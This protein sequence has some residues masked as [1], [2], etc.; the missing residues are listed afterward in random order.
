MKVKDEKS[1]IHLDDDAEDFDT[2]TDID[3]GSSGNEDQDTKNGSN[4]SPGAAGANRFVL[5]IVIGFVAILVVVALVATSSYKSPDD[6]A[7]GIS[8]SDALKTSVVDKTDLQ[9]REP[10]DIYV[11]NYF[12]GKL[13]SVTESVLEVTGMPKIRWDTDTLTLHTNS[14]LDYQQYKGK[15]VLVGYMIDQTTGEPVLQNL[16]EISKIV[17]G[18]VI[19]TSVDDSNTIE[20]YTTRGETKNFEV[21]VDCRYVNATSLTQ[22]FEYYFALG[23][24]DK[25]YAIIGNL[26]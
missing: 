26:E 24:D 11:T 18:S 14:G 23:S 22:Q 2:D 17:R 1:I 9:S 5:A 7:I 15:T 6:L 12:V 20:V 25:V 4:K 21:D 8:A 3:V 13:D 16:S 19:S 10:I